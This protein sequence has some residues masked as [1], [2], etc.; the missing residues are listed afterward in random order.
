M[1]E[2]KTYNG[3]S[4]SEIVSAIFEIQMFNAI[5]ADDIKAWH[6]PSECM[7]LVM[8]SSDKKMAQILHEAGFATTDEFFKEVEDRT[9]GGFARDIIGFCRDAEIDY[10]IKEL[11]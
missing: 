10:I 5:A 11:G 3:K 6:A 8:D 1:F 7:G 9:T 4:L 2:M